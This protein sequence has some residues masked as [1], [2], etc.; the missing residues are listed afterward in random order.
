MIW[1]RNEI[2]LISSLVSQEPFYF[3][4]CAWHFINCLCNRDVFHPAHCFQRRLRGYNSQLLM[5]ITNHVVQG[6]KGPQ[7][8]TSKAGCFIRQSESFRRDH[9][10]GELTGRL[11]KRDLAREAL[12]ANSRG[13][14]EGLGPNTTWAGLN[15]WGRAWFI[16]SIE[17]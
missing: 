1:R 9:D 8:E 12:F 16:G 10:S 2:G 5:S 3:E 11:G 14:M 4:D 7:W 6:H 15:S 13:R 17:M